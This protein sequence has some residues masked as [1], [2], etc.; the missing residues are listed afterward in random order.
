MG[1]GGRDLVGIGGLA[2]E[3][4]NEK[5]QLGIRAGQKTDG[6]RANMFLFIN[7]CKIL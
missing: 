5:T 7:M 1:H 6:A 2:G 4:K 3:E